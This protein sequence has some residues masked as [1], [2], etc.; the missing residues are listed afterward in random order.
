MQGR[1]WFWLRCPKGPCTQIVYTLALKS[2]LFR[3]I[4][5]KYILFGYM[6]PSGEGVVW[7]GP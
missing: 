5:A 2:W 1:G 7:A 4:G 6:D 3:Y